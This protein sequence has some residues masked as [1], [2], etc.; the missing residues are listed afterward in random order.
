MDGGKKQPLVRIA[1]EASARAADQLDAPEA[2]TP[3]PALGSPL[4][5]LRIRYDASAVRCGIGAPVGG[6]LCRFRRLGDRTDCAP[7]QPQGPEDFQVSPSTP[8]QRCSAYVCG[9]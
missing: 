8:V 6:T 3:S 9:E 5:P 1:L 4:P 7:W 2:C